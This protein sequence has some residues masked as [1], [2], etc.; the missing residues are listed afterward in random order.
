MSTSTAFPQGRYDLLAP[1]VPFTIKFEVLGK[2][3][4]KRYAVDGDGVPVEMLQVDLG[5]RK[6]VKIRLRRVEGDNAF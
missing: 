5:Q 2:D 3:W 1:D 6:E 4:E